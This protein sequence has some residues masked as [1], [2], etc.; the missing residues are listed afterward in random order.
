MVFDKWQNGVHVAF[1]IT[2]RQKQ[3][4]LAPWV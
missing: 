3:S 2:T 4:N 1:V